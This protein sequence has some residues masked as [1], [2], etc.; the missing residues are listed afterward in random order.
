MTET[1]FEELLRAPE[2]PQVDFKREMYRL[3][4]CEGQL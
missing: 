3:A 2:G 1:E 4:G